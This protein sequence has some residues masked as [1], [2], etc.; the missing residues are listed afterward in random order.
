MVSPAQNFLSI[1]SQ[2]EAEEAKKQHQKKKKTSHLNAAGKV[3]PE[4]VEG[5][6]YEELKKVFTEKKEL[7]RVDHN[8]IEYL[9]FEKNLYRQVREIADMKEHEVADF[10]KVNHDI[11]VAGK[12]PIPRP[13]KS[14]YQCGFPDKVLKLLEK[15]DILK[16]FPIQMQALPALLAGR[17]C[18]CIAPTGGQFS[19]FSL[20]AMVHLHTC[21][22]SICIVPGIV[23][24]PRSNHGSC[25][26]CF[27]VD[28]L[29]LL[30]NDINRER[31]SCA[32][33]KCPSTV[34][35]SPVQDPARP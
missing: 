1:P 11:R 29:N 9:K 20:V 17:D 33:I 7:P 13:V 3:R 28:E 34:F 19:H 5:K 21:E 22:P 14:F 32:D 12:Q 27:A 15:R 24:P 35:Y 6:T 23:H 2:E 25:C 8:Q 4:H 18:M 31:N 26:H 10:R 30:E 16:P